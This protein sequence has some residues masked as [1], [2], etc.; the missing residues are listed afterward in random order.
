MAATW[1]G[2]NDV[3]HSSFL[4]N[5][6]STASEPAS[7]TPSEISYI[8]PSTYVPSFTWDDTAN[9]I[10][11]IVIAL[12]SP[13]EAEEFGGPDRV[14]L[15]LR[16]GCSSCGGDDGRLLCGACKGP[17]YCSAGCQKKEWK[18]HKPVCKRQLELYAQ[19]VDGGAEVLRE[20]KQE[21][22]HEAGC[23]HHHH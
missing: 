3:L 19:P 10:T 11:S 1:I 2:P 15:V 13:D 8:T 20:R 22:V 5:L 23:K 12:G 9:L 17:V 6:P 16:K 14:S 7:K 18:A 4:A 21:H